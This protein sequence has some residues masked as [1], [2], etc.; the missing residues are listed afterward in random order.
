RRAGTLRRIK[1]LNITEPRWPTQA[2]AQEKYSNPQKK[3]W[4]THALQR[5]PHTCRLP[6]LEHEPA[7]QVVELTLTFPNRCILRTWSGCSH[8]PHFSPR[9]DLPV[10]AL[11]GHATAAVGIDS[12]SPEWNRVVR[13]VLS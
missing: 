11:K 6:I 9:R 3:D 12:A 1:R 10:A 2:Q 5:R 4:H 7:H 8:L 13:F